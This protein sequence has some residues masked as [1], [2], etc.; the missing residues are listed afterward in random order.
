M[1]KEH[2]YYVYILSSKSRAIYTGVTNDLHTR[3]WQHKEGRGGGFTSKY[4]VNRLV[5]YETYQ[6]VEEAILREKR[7]KG[8]IRQKKVALISSRNPTWED[9]SDGWDFVSPYK[10]RAEARQRAEAT[11]GASNKQQVLR[12]A[13]DDKQQQ[14]QSQKQKQ[15]LRCAQDDKSICQDDKS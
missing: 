7:V 13:Q 8:W 6:D 5:Y 14:K 12:C 2:C 10:P 3:V 9:L 15:V 11:L 4:R 1:A